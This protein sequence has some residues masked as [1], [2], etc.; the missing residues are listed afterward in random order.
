MM[1]G[2]VRGG[3]QLLAIVLFFHILI[4]VYA[5]YDDGS[6][7]YGVTAPERFLI[8]SLSGSETHITV[9]GAPK[10]LVGDLCLAPCE[11]CSLD[12][13]P[14]SGLSLVCAEKCRI[15]AGEFVFAHEGDRF[16]AIL[17]QGFLYEQATFRCHDSVCGFDVD[18]G[19]GS[20]YSVH[21][22]DGIT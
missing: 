14:V 22:P 9:S 17:K 4:G 5:V 15:T 21:L 19:D 3:L 1:D 7:R 11:G 6:F 12:C 8:H 18:L 16:E 20:V 2:R 13:Y 10:H